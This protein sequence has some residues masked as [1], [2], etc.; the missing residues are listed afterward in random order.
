MGL[1]LF[2]HYARP[3]TKFLTVPH[4]ADEDAFT[5]HLIAIGI[6]K[7]K[8]V[9]L[10]C[11]AAVAGSRAHHGLLAGAVIV[12]DGAGQFDVFLHG[13][14]WIHAE[15]LINRLITVTEEQRA[16]VALVRHLIWWLYYDLKL[17]RADPT[18]R[19]KA[20]LKARFDRIFG[21]TTGFAELDAALARLKERKAD[22]LVVLD[23]PEVP[24]NTNGSEH[25]VR[26]PVTLRKISGSTRS[27]DG[28]QCRDTFLSLKRTCQKNGISFW[29]YLADRLGIVPGSIVWRDNLAERSAT[30]WLGFSGRGTSMIG[31]F[32]QQIKPGFVCV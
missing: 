8:A 21:R 3:Y 19:A 29:T 9:R 22:L 6:T 23:R 16:A 13:L 10:A 26:D 28:R 4:F 12:S 32:R 31:A 1:L 15:R 11:E 5:D 14:C 2:A 30:I 7:P 20:S 25:D 24:L 18:A 17:Y 27:E